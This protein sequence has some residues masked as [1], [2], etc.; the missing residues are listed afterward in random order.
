MAVRQL[1]AA[2]LLAA[3]GARPAAAQAVA[4]PPR[5]RPPIIRPVEAVA[6]AASIA[7]AAGFDGPL[8]RTLQ[9]DRT[10][11]R[12]DLARVGN[13]FGNLIYTGPLLAV[14]WLAGEVTHRPGLARASLRAVEAGVAAGGVTAVLKLAVG[15]ARPNAGTGPGRFRPF[16][17]DVSFPS[18]HMTVA[19]AVAT[20]L[21]RS[22]PDR[23]TDAAFYGA[24]ALTG[25]ARM[26]DDKHWLSD[27]VAGTAIG[28]LAGRQLN[29]RVGRFKPFAA[30][31]GAGVSVSF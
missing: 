29:G 25:F 21:A 5:A 6:F 15:R 17:G 23:W 30:L 9:A 20:S 27:V 7:L 3:A 19:M 28:Y 10:A 13:A 2:A 26:N 1:W 8:R 18:G 16:G 12:D 24:A 22:T 11:G 4:A 31:G 14:G